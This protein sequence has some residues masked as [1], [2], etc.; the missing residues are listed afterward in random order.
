MADYQPS[1]RRPIA[2]AFRL[3]AHGAVRWCVRHDVHP[4][5]VS[6]AS[7][8]AAALAGLCFWQSGAHPWLVL[9][10]VFFCYTRLWCN[11]LDGMVA[12][13]SGK[14]SLRGELMNE[15]PDRISDVLI[16]VGSAHSGLCYLPGGY[17]AAILAVL[18]AYVGMFGQA[19]GVKRQFGGLMAKQF[20][21]V[22][23]H[24]G[25]WITAGLIWW[26][27][28]HIRFGGL[29]VM[30]WTHLVVVIGCV[31]TIAV[32]LAK[33]LQ[34]LDAKAAAAA[35]ASLAVRPDDAAA[36]PPS[37]GQEAQE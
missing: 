8:V 35:A 15:L 36:Y 11:M 19:V 23:L 9:P 24:I 2:D 29:T 34:G 25:S 30:D 33:I 13:A 10:A 28:G 6:Y 22:T 31:Q 26:N 3:T 4:D 37:A 14:A 7:I 32:R 20:R 18:T 1:A 27:D 5:T 17:W 21:M 16:F 12:I